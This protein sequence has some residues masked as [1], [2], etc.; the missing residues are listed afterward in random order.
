M[1]YLAMIAALAF[2]G[3]A[4]AVDCTECH[5]KINVEEHAEMEATIGTCNDCHDFGSMHEPDPEIHTPE[6]SIK[7]CADCHEL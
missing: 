7:E 5:E 2:A 4:Y 3:S 6:L 1:K